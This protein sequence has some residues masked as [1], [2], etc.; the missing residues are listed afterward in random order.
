MKEKLKTSEKNNEYSNKSTL[1]IMAFNKENYSAIN[2][3]LTTDFVLK[4]DYNMHRRSVPFMFGIP[5]YQYDIYK[6]V[7]DDNNLIK[8][9]DKNNFICF[10]GVTLFSELYKK[11]FTK[12]AFNNLKQIISFMTSRKKGI[13]W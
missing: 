3:L 7:K 5:Y 12:K 8:E 6:R 1:Y 10:T 4:E 9:E 11:V 2:D 13:D